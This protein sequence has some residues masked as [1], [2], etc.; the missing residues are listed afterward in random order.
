MAGFNY[1]LKDTKA[2]KETPIILHINYNK[3][4]AKIY[5]GEKIHPKFWN[6][7][8]QKVDGSAR[9]GTPIAPELNVKLS[10]VKNDAIDVLRKY[11][12]DHEYSD[13]TPQH[14]TKLIYLK[15]KRPN[16]MPEAMD[17]FGYFK[18]YIENQKQRCKL[19]GRNERDSVIASYERSMDLLLEYSKN[20]KKV[21]YESIDIDFYYSFVDFLIKKGF[22][23]NTVGRHIKVLKTILNAA[24]A[25]GFNSKTDFRDNNF[26]VLTEEVDNIYLNKQ[27]LKL[28]SELNLPPRLNGIR[29]SFLLGCWTGLRY[30]DFSRLSGENVD[31]DKGL[32]RIKTKKTKK[33]VVIPFQPESKELFQRYQNGNFPSYAN[34]YM[35]R[36]LKEIGKLLEAKIKDMVSKGE[37]MPVLPKDYSSLRT[38]SGRRSFCS[39][40]YEEG[41]ETTAIMAIS[42]HKTESSF[43]KYIK[44]TPD[45]AAKRFNEL[46][47]EKSQDNNSNES[48]LKIAN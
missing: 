6:K 7:E 46:R 21:S 30:S 3:N 36:E 5:F 15:L 27:E 39:N 17:L 12:S 13:P 25:K 47:N 48:H 16:V 4:R 34:Q 10:K 37:I 38:H 8:E 42:G 40:M 14:L 1:Q 31:F 32:I 33:P 11:Q 20:V 9:T 18:K 2:E 45:E 35:N 26:K 41:I 28:L 43:Y 22:K 19:E 29:D 44:V 24:T 23:K